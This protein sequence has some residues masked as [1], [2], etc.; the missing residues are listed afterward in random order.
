MSIEALADLCCHNAPNYNDIRAIR[1]IVRRTIDR[2]ELGFRLDGNTSRICL[3]LRSQG[4]GPVELWR[5]TCFE[6]FVAIDGQAAYHEFNFAPSHEWRVYAFH[7]YRD[8]A[9]PAN[10]L[11]SP[12]VAINTTAGWLE[13]DAR[14]DLTDL[15]AV[16]PHSPLRL[17]LSAVI[18][19]SDGSLSYW[20]LCHPAGKPDFHHA[21]AFALRVEVPE[22]G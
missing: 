3:K 7:A 22:A 14:I 17:G 13:L 16:H 18:E 1:V 8:P 15:S 10:V 2:L 21:D 4:Q 6:A 12:I 9:P 19:L 20:A 11:R 5:H